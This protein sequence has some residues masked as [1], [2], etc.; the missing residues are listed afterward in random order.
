[1]KTPLELKEMSQYRPLAGWRKDE[2]YIF[3]EEE[4]DAFCDAV[5]DAQRRNC[6]NPYGK[7]TMEDENGA[8][9]ISVNEILDAE[10]P[11]YK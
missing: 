9:Y 8:V 4:L 11:Q 1:M 2:L 6:A 3:T 5:L 7:D 10:E